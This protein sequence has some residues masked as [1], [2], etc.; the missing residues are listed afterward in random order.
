MNKY[1][2]YRRLTLKGRSQHSRAAG[3]FKR[4][5]THLLHQLLTLLLLLLLAPCSLLLPPAPPSCS[6]LLLL[7]PTP[8]PS[9]PSPLL[10]PPRILLLSLL[11][12]PAPGPATGG[13]SRP[14]CTVQVCAACRTAGRQAWLGK[15]THC[16]Q[17]LPAAA[18]ITDPLPN[19]ND[20]GRVCQ[21]STAIHHIPEYAGKI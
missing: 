4:P 15:A 9:C 10:L 11:P 20:I 18:A 3:C 13:A 2:Y 6:S 7:P 12:T 14:L 1:N 8:P 21:A 17:H 5:T 19:S 16:H